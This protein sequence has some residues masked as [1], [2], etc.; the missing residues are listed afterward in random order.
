MGLKTVFDGIYVD[1]LIHKNERGEFVIY[2]YGMMGGGYVLPADREPSVRRRLRLL[3]LSPFVLLIVFVSLLGEAGTGITALTWAAVAGIGVLMLSVL[4]Y[5]QRRLAAG[6]QPVDGPRPTARQWLHGARRSR[7]TWTH[8]FS[9]IAGLIL[10]LL[11]VAAIGA[12]FADGD[13]LLIAS[14]VFLLAISVLAACDGLLGLKE[15][16]G[17]P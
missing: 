15:H 2:P 1:Q 13:L 9:V 8:W 6:L 16:R 12:G 4:I 3:M 17:T 5:F 7:P 14:G 10:G 11:S